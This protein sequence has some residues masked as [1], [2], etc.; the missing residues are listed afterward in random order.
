MNTRRN[1]FLLKRIS[2][3]A[4]KEEVKAGRKNKSNLDKNIFEVNGIADYWE[5]LASLE[6]I[7]VLSGSL[8]PEDDGNCFEIYFPAKELDYFL[9]HRI[10][11]RW[12][13]SED[14]ILF[15]FENNTSQNGSFEKV[16]NICK[17]EKEIEALKGSTSNLEKAGYVWRDW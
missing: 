5:R 15:E 2:S 10:W 6:E 1:N 17:L 9:C 16:I 8:R 12:H 3:L 13:E 14:S 4:K 7:I 11:I